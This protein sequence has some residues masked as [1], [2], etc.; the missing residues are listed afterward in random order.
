VNDAQLYVG[1]RVDSVNCVRKT[2]KTVYA[3]DEDVLYPSVLQ[4]DE[5]VKPELGAFFF[6]GCLSPPVWS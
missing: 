6:I 3:G 5:Y 1:V 4:F 2:F